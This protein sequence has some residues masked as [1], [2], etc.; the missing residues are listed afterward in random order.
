MYP[1]SR[2]PTPLY[3][4]AEFGSVNSSVTM[5]ESLGVAS[6]VRSDV[7]PVDAGFMPLNPQGS[8]EVSHIIGAAVTE[9]CPI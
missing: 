3:D 9:S 4:L 5:S 6:V 8:H 7:L 2:S 1:V